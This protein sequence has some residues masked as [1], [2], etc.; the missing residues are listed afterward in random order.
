VLD[1]RCESGECFDAR[2]K[3]RQLANVVAM[4][5]DAPEEF[6]RSLNLR[7]ESILRRNAEAHEEKRWCTHPGQICTKEKREAW[8]THPGQICTRDA[9]ASCGD[10]GGPCQKLKRAA[11]ALAEAVALPEAQ[12]W[13]T[14]PGQICTKEKRDALAIAEAWCSHPGQIC[15]KAKRDAYALAAAANEVLASL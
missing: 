8:C 12:P 15:T 7:D 14:H 9:E 1:A 2:L 4:T 11:E 3:T 13:C 6:I 10:A 5:R